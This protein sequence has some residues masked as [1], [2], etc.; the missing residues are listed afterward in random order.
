MVG[1]LHPRKQKN[2]SDCEIRARKE[3]CNLLMLFLVEGPYIANKDASVFLNRC[4][5]F[6][7][8]FLVFLSMNSIKS[9]PFLETI[10][11]SDGKQF[12]S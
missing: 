1:A 5:L 11:Q 2:G 8:N 10:S 7:L 6:H 12:I 3:K 9:Q 4:I